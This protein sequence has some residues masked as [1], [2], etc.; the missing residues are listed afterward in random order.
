[1]LVKTPNV[2][3]NAVQTK[4][5]LFLFLKSS[6]P[7]QRRL[8]FNSFYKIFFFCCQSNQFL[9]DL[10]YNLFFQNLYVIRY[11]RVA[12]KKKYKHPILAAT[13]LQKKQFILTFKKSLS[14]FKHLF[15][16]LLKLDRFFF[17]TKSRK[18][19]I[20]AFLFYLSSQKN[21]FFI[22]KNALYLTK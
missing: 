8:F 10:V 1:M 9:L 12:S 14:L 17:E 19:F 7:K 5:I 11:V 20:L 3:T 13:L 18:R 4:E 15:N 21:L 2:T 22:Y 6:L 16:T